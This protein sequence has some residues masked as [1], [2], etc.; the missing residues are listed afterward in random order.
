MSEKEFPP[1]ENK[2]LRLRAEG[3]FP[4]SRDLT[5]AAI[6]GGG[7]LAWSNFPWELPKRF[8]LESLSRG[9]NSYEQFLSSVS[10]A[11]FPILLS[12]LALVLLLWLA[13]TRFYFKPRRLRRRGDFLGT[14]GMGLAMFSLGKAFLVV[15]LLGLVFYSEVRELG[16]ENRQL[17]EGRYRAQLLESPLSCLSGPECSSDSIILP[18]IRRDFG[19]FFGILGA[20]CILSFLLGILSRF[21]AGLVFLREHRMTRGEVEAEA[22]E[23]ESSPMF[24]GY[25]EDE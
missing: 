24:R 12:V 20:S 3:T 19:V 8:F 10:S 16:A 2:L 9:Q 11:L 1:S 5:T 13:Q 4:W 17:A 25:L 15:L 18:R 22:R 14:R 23:G 6:F 21:V 7:L